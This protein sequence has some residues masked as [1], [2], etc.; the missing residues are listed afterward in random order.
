LIL[1][2]LL[3]LLLLAAEEFELNSFGGNYGGYGVF[4]DQGLV[5]AVVEQNGVGVEG[6][7]SSLKSDTINQID[8]NPNS[9]FAGGI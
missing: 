9:L 5:S 4:E 3:G 1:I 7:N 2:F 6:A 8:G